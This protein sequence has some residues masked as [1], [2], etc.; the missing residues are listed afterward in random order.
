[1]RLSEVN[2]NRSI[3]GICGAGLDISTIVRH[4]G[5]NTATSGK[6]LDGRSF[7][8]KQIYGSGSKD[9]YDRSI[10][11]SNLTAGIATPRLIGSDD[12]SKILVFEW[13]EDTGTK[14][15]QVERIFDREWLIGALHIVGEIHSIDLSTGEIVDFI[16]PN[17]DVTAHIS[18][19][20]YSEATAGELEVYQILHSDSLMQQELQALRNDEKE[21]REGNVFIHGDLRVDQF[22]GTTDGLQI[23]DLEESRRGDPARDLGS[24]LGDYLHRILINIPSR[25]LSSCRALSEEITDADVIEAGV[26]A[27]E[28]ESIA[29]RDGISIY[30]KTRRDFYLSHDFLDRSFR[31]SGWHMYDRAFAIAQS[32]NA[33][34]A[35]YLAAAGI[36]RSLIA[37]PGLL[38]NEVMGEVLGS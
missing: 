29:I 18:A 30:A 20:T 33:I 27:L 8:A 4:P 12:T 34:P 37:S 38:V 10:L 22:V 1:M 7:F 16:S 6:L 24:L 25:E 9:R 35:P 11:G 28:R 21:S 14:F 5:R 2:I 13:I 23:V 31:F 15:S 19:E 17:P 32:S 3:E 26:K 36:G